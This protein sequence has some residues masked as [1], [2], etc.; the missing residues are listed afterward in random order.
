MSSIFLV[1]HGQASFGSADYDRLSALGELQVAHL[2]DHLLHIG[3]P[4]HAIYS[5]SLRRQRSTAAIIDG[6]VACGCT[7]LPA[8]DEYDAHSLI[9]RH[10]ALTGMP[11]E[12]LQG[13][14]ATPDHRA[15]QRRLEEVGRAWVAGTLDDPGHE[16]WQAF[17]S[18]VAEGLER[19]M[20][21]EGRSRDVVIATSAGVIGA[22]V[23]HILGLDDLGA[24]RLSWVVLNSS[25][26]R[27]RF[28]GTR[29]SLD[30]FNAVAHLEAQP[31]ARSLLTYR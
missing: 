19:V 18:R 31:Q 13:N 17:R 15:F 8:F 10:S 16:S 12:S 11:L 26:T 7:T 2:R 24:L 27:I 22:A 21:S 3:Q 23:A 4:I 20:A 9:K 25:V 30:S 1:R 28:D 29:C 6:A 14:G 5:G